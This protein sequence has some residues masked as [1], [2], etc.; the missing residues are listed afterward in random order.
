MNG[1][2]H[3]L[4]V[5]FLIVTVVIYRHSVDIHDFSDGTRGCVHHDS[6]EIALGFGNVDTN[7]FA[8]GV[9]MT[10]LYVTPLLLLLELTGKLKITQDSI[11]EPMLSGFLFLF[12][13][14][15]GIASIII[16][17]NFTFKPEPGFTNHISL[18][19]A[20]FTLITSIIYLVETFLVVA[21][22]V[23]K[24]LNMENKAS[25]VATAEV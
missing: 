22:I 23:F 2:R 3:Y 12:L 16:W 9:L 13:L 1:F 8:C 11:L 15:S 24:K 21:L 4:K 14:S 10:G 18:T 7:F 25:A 5:V 17:D 6:G 19:L 20:S